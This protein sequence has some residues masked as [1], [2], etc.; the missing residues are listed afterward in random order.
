MIMDN[1]L[2][3]F[4][5]AYVLCV[6]FLAVELCIRRREQLSTVG[7][8]FGSIVCSLTPIM[9]FG[10][11]WVVI[12]EFLENVSDNEIWNRKIHWK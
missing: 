9:N 11:A 4:L 10:M 2:S 8:M 6:V 7:N 5:W 12:V 1:L 3:A